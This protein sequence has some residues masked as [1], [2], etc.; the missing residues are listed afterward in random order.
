MKQEGRGESRPTIYC[1]P[2]AKGGSAC[3]C[4]FIGYCAKSHDIMKS[5]V[6]TLLAA[7]AAQ[8]VAGH[9]TFQDLWVAGTDEQSYCVRLPPSNNPVTDVTST[10]LRC[11][12]NGLTGVPGKC[13]V[14]AGATVTVE[15]HQQ[16]GDRSCANEAIGGDHFG[17]VQGYMTKVDDAS[18]ADGST[19]WFKIY[20]DTWS[21]VSPP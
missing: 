7:L 1:G 2:P 10:D 20:A 3:S 8:H 18:T 16:P 5:A 12:V 14:T 6:I 11:N 21:P 17:P 4:W 13:T 9:A 19:G 15:M